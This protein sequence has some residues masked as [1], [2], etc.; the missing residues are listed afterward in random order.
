[1]TRVELL[2]LATYF[3]VRHPLR[4]RVAPL[5]DGVPVLPAQV[6]APDARRAASR[7]CR[8]SPCSCRSSTRCTWW[9]GSSEPVC[10]LDYPRDRLEIQV[11][12]DSTDETCE[13]AARVRRAA[14]ASRAST[15]ATSTATNRQGFKAG[16]LE[17]GLA[18]GARA[19]SSRSSTPT[20]CPAPD[21]L[22]RTVPLLHRPAGSGMVQVR[23]EH[24]NRDYSRAHPV[25][26]ASSSTATSS[27]STPRA[28]AR[29]ALLQLQRHRRRLAARDASTTPAAGSTTRS[30]R[31]STSPTARSSRAGSSSSCRR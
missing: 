1:M 16:A 4:L 21:F 26:G 29:G 3:L 8:G 23:W 17:N 19:S 14:G 30:P 7:G 28:T 27:S 15:S 25:P 11:L 22:R 20:S 12:D 13:I 24:L 18:A 6:P 2:F 9:S 10:A 31:T 5:L